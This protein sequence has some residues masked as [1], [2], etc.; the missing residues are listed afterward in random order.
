MAELNKILSVAPM[1]DWTD[2]YCRAFH[3]LLTR[4]ALLYSEMV[5]VG[6]ILYGERA[7]FLDFDAV[8]RPLALQLGGSEPAALAKAAAIAADWGYDEI[9]LNCGCPSDR[10]QQGRFGACLMAEPALVRDCLA[11]MRAAVSIPVTVKCRIGIDEQE[12]YADLLRFVDCVAESGCDTFIVH[13]RKAWLK[14]L[15]PK[16]NR[17]IPPLR[18]DLVRRLKAERPGLRIHL[19]GGLTSLEQAAAALDWADGVML[20]RAAYQDPWLLAE[21]DRRLYGAPPLLADRAQAVEALCELAARH[22]ARGLPLKWL[23]RHTLGLMNGLPGARAWRRTLS[24]GLQD[25]GAGPDL[26]RRAA[27]PVRFDA[28]ES[29]AA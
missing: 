9:N 19:N 8:E 4:R 16:E 20:G 29:L 26:F 6:A 1:M 12:D 24:E 3:R 15:S 10:V 23:G 25:S 11:T 13:A 21:V 5:P 7:R 14:G 28:A 18:H 2:R 22:C 17:E 27:A